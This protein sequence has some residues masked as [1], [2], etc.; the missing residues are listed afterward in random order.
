LSH[1]TTLLKKITKLLG[2]VKEHVKKLK[3]DHLWQVA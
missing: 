2:I 1:T 3:S